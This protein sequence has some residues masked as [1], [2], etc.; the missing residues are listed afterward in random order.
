MKRVHL[1]VVITLMSILFGFIAMMERYLH[2]E[3][4]WRILL[5]IAF[6]LSIKVGDRKYAGC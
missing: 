1:D 2:F 6:P 4:L 3:R 5:I